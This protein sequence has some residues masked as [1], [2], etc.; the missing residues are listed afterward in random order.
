M[1][2][3]STGDVKLKAKAIEGTQEYGTKKDEYNTV[4]FNPVLA[5]GLRIE[6]QLQEKFSGGVHEWKVAE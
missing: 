3:A 1:M 4:R 6:V 2:V 5:E